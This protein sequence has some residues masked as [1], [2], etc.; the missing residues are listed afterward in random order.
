MVRTIRRRPFVVDIKQYGGRVPRRLD[1]T[2]SWKRHSALCEVKWRKAGVA[3]NPDNST[4]KQ[5]F[6]GSGY[7]LRPT[8]FSILV[9]PGPRRVQQSRTCS[10]GSL[11]RSVRKEIRC[12]Q[13]GNIYAGHSGSFSKLKENHKYVNHF[14][15]IEVIFSPNRNPYRC[16]SRFP[17]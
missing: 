15:P 13:P 10:T 17:R 14:W 5:V 1:E 4:R 11:I 7:R 6:C 2:E 9:I 16:F 12:F 3:A 8:S